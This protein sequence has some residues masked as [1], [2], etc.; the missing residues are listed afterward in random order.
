MVDL[1]DQHYPIAIGHAQEKLGWRPEK[2]LRNTLPEIIGRLKT[3]PVRWYEENDLELPDEAKG[4][5]AS[6]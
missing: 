5:A 2:L 4:K 3:D 6:R 1:A